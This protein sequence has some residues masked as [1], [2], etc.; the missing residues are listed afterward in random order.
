MQLPIEQI[1]Q[2][3]L[4]VNFKTTVGRVTK[5]IQITRFQLFANQGRALYN[6]MCRKI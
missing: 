3:I 2:F 4:A 1:I 6:R 5:Q